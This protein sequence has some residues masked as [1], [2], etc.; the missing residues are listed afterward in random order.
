[1][2]IVGGKGVILLAGEAFG[3]KPWE[4]GGDGE[5]GGL[6]LINEKGQFEVENDALGLLGLVW[7][8][9]GMWLIYGL[10]EALPEIYLIWCFE[11]YCGT[12]C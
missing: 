12:M 3:W 4:S 5:L 8:K 1:V 9:P 11:G 7:P 10:S 2:K 6:R